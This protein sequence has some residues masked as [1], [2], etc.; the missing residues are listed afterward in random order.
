MF[1]AFSSAVAATWLL[2]APFVAQNVDT[3]KSLTR[4]VPV[5]LK[6]WTSCKLPGGPDLLQTTPLPQAPMTR[7]AQTL[8]GIRQVKIADGVFAA[9]GYPGSAPFANAKIELLPT[10]VYSSEKASL[11]SEFD[12]INAKG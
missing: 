1:H 6:P 5:A 8:T 10:A 3:A 4:P 9:F 2:T 7:T 11:I 12:A